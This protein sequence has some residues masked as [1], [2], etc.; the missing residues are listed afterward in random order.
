MG[1]DTSVINFGKKEFIEL[2]IPM[3]LF[4]LIVVVVTCV[5]AICE[6]CAGIL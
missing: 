5:V 6:S 4:I 2:I 1:K 3:V